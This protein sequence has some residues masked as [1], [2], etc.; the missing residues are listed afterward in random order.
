MSGLASFSIFLDFDG[1]THPL[2]GGGHSPYHTRPSPFDEILRD[3]AYFRRENLAE[4]NRLAGALNGEIVI[5]SAWR[6]DFEWSAFN[7]LF[8]GC[9]VGQTPWI[10]MFVEGQES[11]RY[12]EV[13]R[14]LAAQGL[15]R[16]PWLALD[17]NRASTRNTRLPTSR[18]AQ[19]GSRDQ[20]WTGCCRATTPG[21]KHSEASDSWTGRWDTTCS[22]KFTVGR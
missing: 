19:R 12:R 21:T 17:D 5:S 13:L 18:T 7:N 22:S 16:T 2:H 20:T 11:L 9:V 6:L 14:F 15:A 1:V 4:V 8:E 10:D 3:P